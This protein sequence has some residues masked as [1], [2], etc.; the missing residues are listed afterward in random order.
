MPREDELRRVSCPQLNPNPVGTPSSIIRGLGIFVFNLKTIQQEAVAYFAKEDFHPL[1]IKL[2][3]PTPTTIVERFLRLVTINL[4]AYT[5]L[6]YNNSTLTFFNSP[7]VAA[8]FFGRSGPLQLAATFGSLALGLAMRPL[9]GRALGPLGDRLGRKTLTRI[10]SVGSFLPLLGIALL[11]DYGKI[12]LTAPVAFLILTALQGFFTGSLSGGINVIG[13]ESLEE[14][15]RGWF[16]GSGMAVSG[17]SFLVASGIFY[18]LIKLVGSQAYAVWGWRIMF[19]TSFLI[20]VFGFLMPESR[21]FSRSKPS[22]SSEVF[23]DFKR[24]FL[25]A[26]ALTA[27]W[28]S[29]AFTAEGL[30]PDFLVQVDHFGSVQV[31]HILIIY[32]VVTAASGFAGG[33][34][35]ELLGRRATSILGG[36]LA[37]GA[38][39][40][41][42]ALGGANSFGDAALIVGVLSWLLVFGGGG[43]MAYVNECFPT[44][45]R[46][47]GVALAWNIGFT[48]AGVST[49]LITLLASRIGSFPV[50]EAWAVGVLSVLACVV[51]LAS[52]ETK[53]LLEKI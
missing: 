53:G 8:T 48:T 16:S 38:V 23:R 52:K 26:A 2:K 33:A 28:G 43:I 45:V 19:S 17:T 39:P 44:G 47:S 14:R 20:V 34:L 21:K 41:Y 6:V 42:L 24:N 37:L 25:F 18:G 9:G 7:Y 35:S 50:A 29:L 36:V 40:L 49:L 46:S 13:I 32:S 11:P 51:S 12:G 22:A 1:A 5:F 4:L 31:D 15:H 27:I 3:G 10:G 30:L